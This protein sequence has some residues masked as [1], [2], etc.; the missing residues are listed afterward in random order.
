MFGSR[1]GRGDYRNSCNRSLNHFDDTFDKLETDNKNELK[2]SIQHISVEH[3]T[4]NLEKINFKVNPTKVEDWQDSNNNSP[5]NI[6]KEPKISPVINE[7]LVTKSVQRLHRKPHFNSNNFDFFL[8]QPLKSECPLRIITQGYSKANKVLR[9]DFSSMSIVL[10]TDMFNDEIIFPAIN[11]EFE[12]LG[13]DSMVFS[14]S[15]PGHKIIDNEI[16]E[17]FK[18]IKLYK[19]G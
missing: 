18:E 16:M 19:V 14:G 6:H 4:K 9:K 11:N 5:R 1:N 17:K 10:V 7:I 12:K 3:L 15:R 8:Q 13:M 2:K